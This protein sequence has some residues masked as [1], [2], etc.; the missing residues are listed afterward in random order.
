MDLVPPKVSLMMEVMVP[1]ALTPHPSSCLSARWVRLVP[2]CSSQPQ[3]LLQQPH[4][5]QN[6][7]PQVG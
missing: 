4:S 1:P 2:V 6:P 7:G 3:F 5:A